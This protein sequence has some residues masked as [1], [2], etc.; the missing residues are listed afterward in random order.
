MALTKEQKELGKL[1]TPLQRRVVHGVVEGK[2]QRQAYLD[3]G[4][5]SATEEAQDASASRI[6]SDIKVK[7]YHD[8]L[9]ASAANKAILTREEALTMLS[10][11][12][13]V[14]IAD[15]CDFKTVKTGE[16]KDGND[17]FQT[18]WVMKNAEDIE[19][20]IA[21]CIK[22]VTATTSGLKI[23]LHDSQNALDKLAKLEGWEADKK[24]K[25]SGKIEVTGIEREIID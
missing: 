6:L 14:T 5:T 21:A 4:G 19:P 16:D 25:V 20:H 9:M 17:I 13:R 23:E 24:F 3:A 8:A 22:S 10:N 18:T 7:A 1:L 12:A 2:S 11:T 15:V